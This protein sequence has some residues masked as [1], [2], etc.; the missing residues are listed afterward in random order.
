MA[1]AVIKSSAELGSQLILTP[2]R[3]NPKRRLDFADEDTGILLSEL[4]MK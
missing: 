4:A 3:Y 1:I 2:E